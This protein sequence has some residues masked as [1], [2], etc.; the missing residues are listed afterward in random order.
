MKKYPRTKA[1][2]KLGVSFVET[3]VSEDGSIFRETPQDT[4]VGI[5]GY[6]EFVENDI[7]TG[8]LV[9][10]QIKAG[11]SFLKQYSDGMYFSINA[12]RADINYWNSHAIPVALIAYDPTTKLSGWLDI[13]GYIRQNPKTLQ[14]DNAVL[15]IHSK[16]SAFSNDTFASKFKSTFYVYRAE[17]DLFKF[18]N[19][20]VALDGEKR[21]QGFLGLMSHPRSRFSEITCYL[22]IEHL[23]DQNYNLRVSTTD[24]LSRY[25]SHPEVGFYPPKEIRDYVQSKLKEF[26]R[27]QIV[28][29]LETAW[30]DEDISMDRGTLGQCAGVII[31]NIPNYQSHLIYIAT[32]NEFEEEIRMSA[33]A[34]AE[35]FGLET[36]IEHIINNFDRVDWGGLRDNVRELVESYAELL[37]APFLS[38]IET[39]IENESYNNDEIAYALRD[40]GVPVLISNEYLVYTIEDRT[41]NPLVKFYAQRASHKI[42]RYKGQST[43]DLLPGMDGSFVQS[44]T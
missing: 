9:G 3:I 43:Q 18:T 32:H 41:T 38:V 39:A 40:A 44:K 5:D 34:L 25:L 36:I 23:F 1:T 11:E 20:I 28:Q 4:D 7:A 29:L 2:G 17:A 8:T 30:L 14:K 21:L 33:L 31:I 13:T 22:L 10:V 37:H 12:S 26:D 15:T 6:I 16:S 24:A 42:M 27:D 19:L 35:S